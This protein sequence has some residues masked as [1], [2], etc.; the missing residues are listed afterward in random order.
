M[1]RWHYL[2]SGVLHAQALAHNQR[3][4]QELLLHPLPD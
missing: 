2:N 4:L 3:L 1:Q